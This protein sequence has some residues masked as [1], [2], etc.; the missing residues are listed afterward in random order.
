VIAA[1]TFDRAFPRNRR[2]F[3]M[4]DRAGFDVEVCQADVWGGERYEIPNRRKLD[5]L[6]QALLA[7]PRLV[8]RFL[9][10]PRGDV[11]L[12][13]YP[14]WFDML[15]IGVLARVRRM[16]VVFDIFI[17]L[18]DTV[19]SD[20]KLTSPTS[21]LGRACKLA[22]VVSLRI[23]HR[24]LADTPSHADFFASLAGIPRERVGVVWL[25]AQDDV[26]GPQPSV[27]PVPNRVMFHGTFLGLQG[28]PTI[29]EAAKLLEDDGI[30]FRIIGSGQDSDAIDRLLAELRPTNVEMVGRVPVEQVPAEIAAG[31]VCLGIFGTSEKALRVAPNKLYECVAVGRPV[32]TADSDAIRAAFTSD[33]VA[34]VPAGDPAALAK[35]IR[36]LIGDAPAREMMAK[37]GH[38]RYVRDYSDEPLSRLLAS[39]LQRAIYPGAT[40][41]KASAKDSDR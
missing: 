13:M 5:V 12:V 38:E 22:D 3:A 41:A 21:L 16:P 26:F 17:S 6:V 19:V 35:E 20:R 1:G 15:V 7:Y 4:L 40:P 18:Y 23:A 36:W 25:G 37:A 11:V 39:E 32:I 27:A 31:T 29:I 2:L 33:E 9:R 8:W 34:T 10:V 24:V 28:L 30:P 14:G